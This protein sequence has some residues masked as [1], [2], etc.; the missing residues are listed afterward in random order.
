MTSLAAGF[1]V[2]DAASA[3]DLMWLGP[4]S[5]GIRVITPILEDT[6]GISRIPHFT[7]RIELNMFGL[8]II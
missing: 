3:H 7:L 4:Q 8:N 6:P 2:I 1:W 5:L